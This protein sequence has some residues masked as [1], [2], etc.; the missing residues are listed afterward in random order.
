MKK[1]VTAFDGSDVWTSIFLSANDA[2][3]DSVDLQ[4]TL[5]MTSF[6]A[7]E[8][9]IHATRSAPIPH[10]PA[11]TWDT[12]AAA[13]NTSA[14]QRQLG[15]GTTNRLSAAE[16]GIFDFATQSWRWVNRPKNIDLTG[17][18]F[19]TTSAAGAISPSAPYYHGYVSEAQYSIFAEMAAA[20][21]NPALALQ[22][23][24]TNLFATTYYDRIVMFDRALPCSKTPL[25]KSPGR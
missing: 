2:A 18:T 24:F 22:A 16:R 12:V 10:E 19:S 23:F 1:A 3:I 4:V 13:Y 20:T 17:G 14:V 7:Q 6:E 15:G 21:S 5:C 9:N 25:S 8:M 11:L